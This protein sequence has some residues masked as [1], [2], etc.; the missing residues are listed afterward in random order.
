[1]SFLCLVEGEVGVSDVVATVEGG[2]VGRVQRDVR[3]EAGRPVRIGQSGRSDGD[4][5]EWT[6]IRW[7]P[8]WASLSAILGDSRRTDGCHLLAEVRASSDRA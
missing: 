7:F 8:L 2:Q 3:P 5:V 4:D 1:V 6:L